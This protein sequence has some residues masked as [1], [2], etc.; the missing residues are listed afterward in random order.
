LKKPIDRYVLT[1]I[2]YVKGLRIL[3]GVFFFVRFSKDPHLQ[4][5]WNLVLKLKLVDVWCVAELY[6]NRVPDEHT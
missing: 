3:V 4:Q 1:Y 6:L 2:L 5:F